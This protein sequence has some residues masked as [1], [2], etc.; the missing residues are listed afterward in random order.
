MS[1][2]NLALSPSFLKFKKETFNSPK[3]LTMARSQQ[4]MKYAAPL[5]HPQPKT[6]MADK[7]SSQS[8]KKK[9]R[10]R[11]RKHFKEINSANQVIA[12]ENPILARKREKRLQNLKE[13]I[14]ESVYLTK[15]YPTDDHFKTIGFNINSRLVGSLDTFKNQSMNRVRFW[16]I[17]E[18]S[19]FVASI[20]GCE[21]FVNIFVS[22]VS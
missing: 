5:K 11:P 12:T 21:K 3:S 18:V 13:R 8:T 1:S 2:S 4:G 22:Q 19:K 15:E 9:K 14:R 7:S 20:P 10:G 17:D 16:S 6:T